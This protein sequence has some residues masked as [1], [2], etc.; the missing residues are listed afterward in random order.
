M[1]AD[2][3]E[4]NPPAHEMDISPTEKEL[5]VFAGGRWIRSDVHLPDGYNPDHKYPLMV[6]LHGASLTAQDYYARGNFEQLRK[7]GYVIVLPQAANWNSWLSEVL[8]TTHLVTDKTIWQSPTLGVRVTPLSIGHYDKGSDDV[9]AVI[10]TVKAAEQRYSID[11]ENIDLSGF[12]QGV[13]VA[14]EVAALL[15]AKNP[16]AVRNLFL[17]SGTVSAIPDSL[18]GTNVVHYFA[19]SDRIEGLGNV[20]GGSIINPLPGGKLTT[21][22]IIA[23]K[24]GYLPGTKGHSVSQTFDTVLGAHINVTR[25]ADG[26]SVSEIEDPAAQHCVPGQPLASD[27]WWGHCSVQAGNLLNFEK[28]T[29]ELLNNPNEDIRQALQDAIAPYLIK[30]QQ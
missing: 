4:T 29:E 24:N 16:G 28:L 7:N 14:T 13:S 1:A 11:K 10:G 23:G 5:Q 26:T 30:P 25:S 15:D 9:D 19:S 27:R 18:K 21:E 6:A 17:V 8:T 12:S 2:A 20:L 22:N 3:F